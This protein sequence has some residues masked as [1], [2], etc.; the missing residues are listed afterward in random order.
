LPEQ[1]VCG[2]LADGREE[3]SPDNFK[4]HP[5]FV[6]F[7]HSICVD[8]LDPALLQYAARCRE[9]AIA[10]IDERTSDVNGAVPSEDILGVYH[11]ENGTIEKYSPNPNYRLV[12]AAGSFKLTSW[13]RQRLVKMV[14]A[15]INK[16]GS[17]L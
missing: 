17:D 15:A 2:L 14:H 10:L 3:I 5:T 1:C 6:E 12:S 8:V 7:L 11:V 4:E 16:S 13:L 9:T